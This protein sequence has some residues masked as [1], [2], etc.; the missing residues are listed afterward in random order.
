MEFV[1]SKTCLYLID[2]L[3][4]RYTDQHSRG[5]GEEISVSSLKEFN[6]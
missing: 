1:N 6:V 5:R 3:K 4:H 2:R